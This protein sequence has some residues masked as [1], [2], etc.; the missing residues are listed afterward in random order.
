[1]SRERARRMA[2]TYLM[3]RETSTL[4]SYQSSFK[5]LVKIC[6]GIEGSIFSLNEATRCEVWVECQRLK[7][8]A[9]GIKGLSAV[10]SLVLEVMGMEERTSGRERVLKRSVIKCSNLGK[11]KAKRKE[12]SLEEVLAL[13]KEAKRTRS[14]A[15]FRV[16]MMAAV[17]FFGIRRLADI[18]YVKVSDVV[19]G[20]DH[21][22]IYMR[23]HKTDVE[24]VGEYFTVAKSGSRFNLDRFMRSYIRVMGVSAGDALFPIEL[25]EGAKKRSVTYNAMYT[26]LE[27]MKERLGLEKSLTWH[28]WRIGAATRGTALGV[29]RNI[30]KKAGLWRSEA[31]DVYCRET[32]PGVVLS[33]ALANDEN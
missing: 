3:G 8:S 19:R 18:Q 31:V 2:E 14:R 6:Q 12:G 13:V 32:N 23:R 10:M 30:I 15:D 33:L 26:S 1:M 5:K 24:S 28:S 9:S 22:N 25:G 21:L 16:A 27:S 11:K 17:C 7:V 20:D 4:K 29:R